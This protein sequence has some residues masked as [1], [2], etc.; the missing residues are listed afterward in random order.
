M[1]GRSPRDLRLNALLIR[2]R[3]TR[4]RPELC[5]QL[6]GSLRAC[7]TWVGGGMAP[8]QKETNLLPT[9]LRWLVL[10]FVLIV[11]Q[12]CKDQAPTFTDIP[13]VWYG[14]FDMPFERWCV[15]AAIRRNVESESSF[16]LGLAKLSCETGV[17][18]RANLF[19]RNCVSKKR[20]HV[21]FFCSTPGGP[22]L[23]S[24]FTR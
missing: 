16:H 22:F 24:R 17:E 4:F 21:Q 3:S 19:W 2:F 14:E 9:I 7:T 12:G 5:T 1:D 11:N 15:R 13:G 18:V 10:P 8:F 23:R 20:F 6:T